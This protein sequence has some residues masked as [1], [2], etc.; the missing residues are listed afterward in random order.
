MLPRRRLSRTPVPGAT[1]SASAGVETGSGL[2]G[3]RGEAM[4]RL[5]VGV[6]GLLSVLFLV[7]IAGSIL[8]SAQ[9]ADETGTTTTQQETANE[10]SSDPLVDIGVA[11]ELPGSEAVVVPDLPADQMPPAAQG[12]M[13]AAPPAPAGN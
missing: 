2:F 13:P 9:K 10:Q 1:A 7:A 12:D 8:E 6:G 3:T 5:K 11:P 4:H